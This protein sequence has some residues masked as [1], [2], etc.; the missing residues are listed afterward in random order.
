MNDYSIDQQCLSD[1]RGSIS[2]GDRLATFRPALER[3]FRCKLRNA[4]DVEDFVQ[5]VFVRITARRGGDV[6]NLG[7]YVFQTAASVLADG[8]RRRTVRHADAQVP[9]DSDR[10]SGTDFDAGRIVESREALR[11]VAAALTSLPERT[12]TIFLMR[13]L[14]GHAYKDIASNFGISVSAVE[15]RMM[16]AVAQ[17]RASPGCALGQI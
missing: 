13:R 7:G 9:F 12:R 6:E 5:E 8:H 4:S 10:H 1:D 11:A 17:L 14:D 16:S 2:T 15:K 3:Y